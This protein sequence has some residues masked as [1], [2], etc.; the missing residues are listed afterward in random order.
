MRVNGTALPAPAPVRELMGDA[1]DGEDGEDTPDVLPRP[2]VGRQGS[3]SLLVD[4]QRVTVR[5]QLFHDPAIPME[6]GS[7]RPALL[8]ML[9]DLPSLE[10]LV[11]Q[12]TESH[13]YG[14]YISA[15]IR[16]D[17]VE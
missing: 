15:S 3:Q 4:D 8:I 11:K 1:Q 5:G 17:D 16:V 6:D 13:L 12:L 2:T 10:Y 7:T 14:Q 9:E